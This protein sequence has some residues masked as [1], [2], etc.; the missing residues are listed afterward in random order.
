LPLDKLDLPEHADQINAKLASVRLP[1]AY[2]PALASVSMATARLQAECTDPAPSC[3]HKIAR[4]VDADRLLWAE[5]DTSTK[6]AKKRKARPGFRLSISLFDRDLFAVVGR[7]DGVFGT[8]TDESLDRLIAVA[9]GTAPS[10]PLAPRSWPIPALPAAGQPAA[11][12]PASA[13]APPPAP[14][15]LPAGTPPS[16]PPVSNP[17]TPTPGY[18]APAAPATPTA[19][20]LPSPSVPNPGPAPSVPAPTVSAPSVSTPSMSAPSA[21]PAARYP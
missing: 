9:T 17:A 5:V 20:D 21:A 3:Y 16:Y 2:L 10:A 14:Y 19:P 12:P 15:Y 7:A 11:L 8:L 1:G 6:M 18:Y 4:L 13:Q